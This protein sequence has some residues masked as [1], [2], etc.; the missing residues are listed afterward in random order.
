VSFARQR[1]PGLFVDGST[2]TGAEFEYWDNAIANAG[3]FADG[4]TYSLASDMVIGG[5][6]FVAW[7]FNLQTT[8]NAGVIFSSTALFT[9]DITAQGLATFDGGVTFNGAVVL[10]DYANFFGAA[11]FQDNITVF[12][13]ASLQ[14]GVNLSGG[15]QVYD[16]ATF[17]GSAAFAGTV[18][19]S[20]SGNL[21]VRRVRRQT[22][23]IDLDGTVSPTT[24]DHLIM[25]SGVPTGARIYTIDDTGAVN[26]DRFRATNLDSSQAMVIKRPDG[27]TALKTVSSASS[28]PR[29]CDFE[30]I[31][32]LWYAMPGDREP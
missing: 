17:N 22:Y 24:T 21:R 32:G 19:T 7:V 29:W 31:D 30:R 28:Y 2:V 8:F 10:N 12:G 11:D 6:P 16:A 5:D 4:G 3:D 15:T 13:I 14:G 27:V 23:A 25:R 1:L 26:G 18:T 9:G 20:G